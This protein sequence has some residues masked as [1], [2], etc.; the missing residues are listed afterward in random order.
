MSFLFNFPGAQYLGLDWPDI[1]SNPYA[2]A[3]APQAPAPH[4]GLL[5]RLAGRAV[6]GAGELS[7]EDR[8][9]I[10]LQGLLAMG[11]GI[12]ANNKGGNGGAAIG[13]GITQGLLA[14]N[15]GADDLADRKYR[16]VAFD[17]S[18]AAQNAAPAQQRYIEWLAS[19][20]PEN[21][22]QDVYRVA[23]GTAGRASSAGFQ[24]IKFVGPDK[25]ERV[26][27]F[28][29]RSGRIETPDGLSFE[30]G[31]VTPLDFGGPAVQGH[32]Y[33]IDPSL[34][35]AVQAAIRQ[36]EATGQ[37]L[38]P[39]F[40]LT[41][42]TPRPSPSAGRNPF[43]GPTPGEVEYDKERA[44]RAALLETLPTE[45][46]M[47]TDAAI[48]TAGGSTSASEAAKNLQ[49]ARRN[50]PK[51]IQQTQQTLDTIAQLENNPDLGTI[52]GLSGKFDPRNYMPGTG[53]QGAKALDAQLHGQAFLAAFESLKGGGQITEV[54]GQKA[55]DALARL[56]RAQSEKDY[57]AALADYRSVIEAGLKRA[58]QQA[59]AAPQETS[60]PRPGATEGGYRFKGGDPADPNSWEQL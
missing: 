49:D 11:A 32:G 56:N 16:Q 18:L 52:T 12:M 35:P 33:T 4:E 20:V 60:G 36:S 21:E 34:P 55:T 39:T 37:P 46:R 57:R 1:T 23:A 2:P 28:N 40:D 42:A 41:P 58:I 19:Q 47:R 59:G 26:G 10:G 30:P 24:T 5:G 7:P 8:R 45:M 50:L 51:V 15:R 38:P 3:G 29:P 48:E 6:P 44:K 14:M 9:A 13:Q 53:A 17:K 22:R 25:R 31:N 54:E 27:V 43:T